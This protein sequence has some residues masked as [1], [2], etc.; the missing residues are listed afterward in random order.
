M[1][2]RFALGIAFLLRSN[3][4]EAADGKLWFVTREDI[5]VVAL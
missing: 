2:P 3:F 5:G 1:V 4:A